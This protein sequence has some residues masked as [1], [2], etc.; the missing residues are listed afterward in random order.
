VATRLSLRLSTLL[1][2][3]SSPLN[4][5]TSVVCN[6]IKKQEKAKKERRENGGDLSVSQGLQ[7]SRPTFQDF[8]AA[9]ISPASRS[10]EPCNTFSQIGC[11]ELLSY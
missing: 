3:P 11:L 10:G 1:E 2:L 7:A 9:V 4:S 5:Q 8:F 6:T